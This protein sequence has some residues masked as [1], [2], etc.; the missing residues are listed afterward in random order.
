MGGFNTITECSNGCLFCNTLRLQN[1]ATCL[2]IYIIYLYKR[3][4][5]RGFTV[6]Y[7]REVTN[8]SIRVGQCVHVVYQESMNYAKRI[9]KRAYTC[10]CLNLLNANSLVNILAPNAVKLSKFQ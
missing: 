2:H 6:I 3:P 4:V 8:K 10:T 9:V 1:A 7:H 5:S